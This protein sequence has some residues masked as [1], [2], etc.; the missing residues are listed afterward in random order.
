MLA[1]LEKYVLPVFLKI[2][3]NKVLVAIRNGLTLTIPFT[4]V[5][6]FFLILGNLPIKAWTDF[7][8]PVSGMLNA[9]V[10]VTFGILGL[11]VAI[12][13]GYNLAIGLV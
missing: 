13:I 12:G 6:S 8:E 4:I 7:I 10:S 5:G 11:I 1:G 3:E 9:P 2:G